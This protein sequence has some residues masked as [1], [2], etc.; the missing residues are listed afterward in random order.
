MQSAPHV[1]ICLSFFFY[2][3]QALKIQREQW[4]RRVLLR[5]A[6][7]SGT[8]GAPDMEHI[9][10]M[11]M[12]AVNN[13]SNSYNNNSNNDNDGD[14][15]PSNCTAL[16]WSPGSY[17]GDSYNCNRSSLLCLS[18][19]F[20][21]K[22][23]LYHYNHDSCNANRFI[24]SSFYIPAV[25]KELHLWNNIPKNNMQGTV[26]RGEGIDRML[27]CRWGEVAH[28]L[29]SA[30]WFLVCFWKRKLFVK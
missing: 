27:K 23:W 21:R 15:A 1:Q 12:S 16:K 7:G 17:S 26:K 10:R 28:V 13:N 6:R 11:W 3:S 14:A 22:F 29:C 8:S 9:T 18:R 2:Y 5:A 30:F 24:H 25:M 19:L 4:D 20:D